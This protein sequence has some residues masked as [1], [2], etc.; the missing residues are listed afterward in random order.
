M[1]TLFAYFTSRYNNGL[2]EQSLIEQVHAHKERYPSLTNTDDSMIAWYLLNDDVKTTY[3]NDYDIF[4]QPHNNDDK[5][6]VN[7]LHT[8]SKCNGRNIITPL[9]PKY[10]NED[11]IKECSYDKNIVIWCKNESDCNLYGDKSTHK[12]SLSTMI[13][14]NYG[15]LRKKNNFL[16]RLLKLMYI[17]HIKIIQAGIYNMYRTFTDYKNLEAHVVF[18]GRDYFMNVIQDPSII[19]PILITEDYVN[20]WD[21][22]TELKEIDNPN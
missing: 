12:V 10:S 7:I 8:E 20:I 17:V 19:L 1:F 2:V 5:Y 4:I 11:I 22:Y 21:I 6:S 3:M 18:K 13:L 14:F 9:Y 15:I 16:N